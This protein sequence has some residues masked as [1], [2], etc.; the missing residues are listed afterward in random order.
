[1]ST[2]GQAKITFE[3]D[4]SQVSDQVVQKLEKIVER[5]SSIVDK[6]SQDIDQKSSDAGAALGDNIN[7]DKHLLLRDVSLFDV[8]GAGVWG[9]GSLGESRLENVYAQRCGVGFVLPPDSFASNCTAAESEAHG[10][11]VNHGSGHYANCKA[12]RA[13]A[14]VRTDLADQ[15]VVYTRKAAAGFYVQGSGS[16]SVFAACDA[17]NNGGPGLEI[18]SPT[19]SLNGQFMLDANNIFAG[20]GQIPWT[21]P[22]PR[23]G[24]EITAHQ[25]YGPDGTT[26]RSLTPEDYPGAIIGGEGH[27]LHLTS[28][29][30][31]FQSQGTVVGFQ[32]HGIDISGTT[33]S[34][35]TLGHASSSHRQDGSTRPPSSPIKPGWT[36]GE[37]Y[38]I[39][40]GSRLDERT[41]P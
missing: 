30:A 7:Y 20:F 41:T 15:P 14:V 33:R 36:P 10:F 23:V 18:T 29:V 38:V 28:N 4:T 3:A 11:V 2:V 22:T 6:M 16:N 32:V 39:A 5:L 40:N 8:Y 37:N 17:Q 24:S 13:G 12:F 31:G 1:M 21:I 9:W 26:V 27:N 35:I 25:K 34:T 19:A